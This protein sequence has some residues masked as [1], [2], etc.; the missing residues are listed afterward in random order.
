M[1]GT[2]EGG[3]KS[4]EGGRGDSN[5]ANPTA[6][7]KYLKGIDFPADKNEIVNQAKDNDAPDDVMSAIKNLPDNEY[8]SAVD[9]TKAV[10]QAH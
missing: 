1:T 8:R 10:S 4:S 3:R 6:I 7:E 5:K 9:V 2:T